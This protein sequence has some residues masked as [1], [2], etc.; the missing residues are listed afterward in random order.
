V[1]QSTLIKCHFQS[2]R[3]S[4][5]TEDNHL[6]LGP[7]LDRVIPEREAEVISSGLDF[8][9]SD[10]GWPP[11]QKAHVECREKFVRWSRSVLSN[12]LMYSGTIH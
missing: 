7:H 9:Y 4:E 3:L 6:S 10:S 1:E 12:V 8:L 5:V 2:L 11:C